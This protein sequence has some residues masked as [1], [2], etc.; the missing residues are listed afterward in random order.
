MRAAGPLVPIGPLAI[1]LAAV[2]LSAVALARVGGRLRRMSQSGRLA[3]FFVALL[4]PAVAMY[5][6]LL[7]HATEAK[8]RLVA[9][10]F[11]SQ[12]A[13]LREDLQRKTP[14]MIGPPR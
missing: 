6:S 9:T 14:N 11:G 3:V 13:T 4:A 12:A 7:A 2:G 8:E 10:E 5:P 1:A